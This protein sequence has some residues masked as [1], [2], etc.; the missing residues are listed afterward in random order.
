MK[1]EFFDYLIDVKRV[2]SDVYKYIIFW[3]KKGI[4]RIFV[5][6]VFNIE[7]WESR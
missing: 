3:R 4:L 6:M 7:M 1:K 2:K 5:I